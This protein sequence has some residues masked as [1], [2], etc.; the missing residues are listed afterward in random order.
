MTPDAAPPLLLHVFP[1]F[2]TGGAQVRCTAVINRFAGRWRHA[3]VALD[4]DLS[5]CERINPALDVIYP[6][7]LLPKRDTLR[8]RHRARDALREIAPSTLITTNW[9]SIEWAMA[10]VPSLVRHVHIEEGLGPDEVSRQFARR[11][12]T[13][14]VVLRHSTVAVP[15]HGLDRMARDV[16]HLPPHRL[17]LIPNGVD[18]AR[19]GTPAPRPIGGSEP[20]VIGTVAALRVEKNIGRLLQAFQIV[21]QATSARLVIV[22]D[23][24]ERPKLE[25]QAGTLGIE[26]DVEFVGHMAQPEKA[27]ARFDVFVLSSDTEQMPLSVLEAM[28]ARLPV[29]STD[30][31]D[32]RLMVAPENAAFIVPKETRALA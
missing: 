15:S 18:L 27:F 21:R 9:G 20:L 26:K 16:W 5:C 19:F 28:A 24:P 25:A 13:R 32:I 12:W 1:S 31:G 10:N 11:I 8:A 3:I 14:R 2:A 30:V 29:A 22:G 4:G 23:G 7:V 6:S 17:R